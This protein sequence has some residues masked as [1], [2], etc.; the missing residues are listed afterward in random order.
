[1][2]DLKTRFLN[3]YDNVPINLRKQ[4]IVII[5]VDGEEKPLSWDVA[6]LEVKGDTSLGKEILEKLS[7]MKVI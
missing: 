4:L 5:K 7:V 2:V 1:M 6:Y 3:A